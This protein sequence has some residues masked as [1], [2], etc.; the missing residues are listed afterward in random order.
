MFN[1]IKL[2]VPS[3]PVEVRVPITKLHYI[4]WEKIKTAIDNRPEPMSSP[5]NNVA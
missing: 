5:N 2:G 1:G 3:K 4:V